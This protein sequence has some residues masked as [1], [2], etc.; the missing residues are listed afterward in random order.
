MRRYIAK[1]YTTSNN[2]SNQNTRTVPNIIHFIYGFIPQ[3]TP[4]EY[5]KY[6]AITSAYLINKPDKMYFY[7]KYEPFG[8][9]WDKVKH[10]L[11]LKKIEPPVYFLGKEIK[12]YAHQSDILRL[13]IL[14][15]YGGIYLDIDTICLKSLKDFFEFNL[16][17]GYQGDHGLC[18]AILIAKPQNNFIKEWLQA[19]KTFRSTGKDQFYDEHSVILPMKMA[20]NRTDINVLEPNKF[21]YPLA[22]HINNILF[23]ENFNESEKEYIDNNCYCIHLWESITYDT[24]KNIESN[25]KSLY[26][27]YSQNFHI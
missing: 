11:E 8:F 7:Y 10:L 5:Y 27:T 22:E 14:Y 1:Q 18:N 26:Y 21:F 4:F 9:Y 23:T 25:K 15:N 16:T 13:Q 17:I 19:Y 2:F 3:E 12:H 24:I 6:I 20:F